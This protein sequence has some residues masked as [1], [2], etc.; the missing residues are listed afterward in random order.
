VCR[1]EIGQVDVVIGGSFRGGRA[2]LGFGIGGRS[3]R[4]V[5]TQSGQ[6]HDVIGG[7]IRGR[8]GG[9]SLFRYR[10]VEIEPGQVHEVVGCGL[11]RGS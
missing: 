1:I 4:L 7:V 5:Q 10:A 2:G 8:R 3:G 9:R 11:G 6:I